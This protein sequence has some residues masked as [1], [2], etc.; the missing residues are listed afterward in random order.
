MVQSVSRRTAARDLL[1]ILLFAPAG[2]NRQ[3]WLRKPQGA[4]LPYKKED[5]DET[6]R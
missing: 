5:I 4:V 6:I 1:N 2:Q 3:T